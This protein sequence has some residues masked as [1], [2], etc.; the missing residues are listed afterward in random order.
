M[1]SI[2]DTIITEYNIY[3]AIATLVTMV[4]IKYI[5]TFFFENKFK[6]K[7][8]L[9]KAILISRS[10][11]LWIF[12]VFV[13]KDIIFVNH[14]L[15]GIAFYISKGLNV[16]FVYIVSFSTYEILSYFI[17]MESS[18]RR[19][20]S[21]RVAWKLLLK[22]TIFISAIIITLN[23]TG[24][25]ELMGL[26]TTIASI[27]VFL[28]LTSSTWFP[29][30]KS[31]LLMLF[32]NSLS[33]EDVIEVPELDIYGVVNSIGLFSTVIRNEIDNHRILV[34]NDKLEKS[35]INNIS[36]LSRVGGLREQLIFNIG[37]IKDNGEKIRSEEIKEY[38]EEAFKN[39]KL[40]KLDININFEK[41]IEIFL[42]NPGDHALTWHV[43]YFTDNIKTRIKDK[44]Y[45]YEIFYNCSIKYNIGLDTPITS[46][47]LEN[48]IKGN[49]HE[50]S[51]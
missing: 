42:H 30:I 31:G 45:M 35:V 12:M 38:F 27:G 49:F 9:K 23:I 46:V 34:A 32:S 40:S 20:S 51:I 4:L 47:I 11:I 19:R 29:P 50:K 48:N 39:A 24:L 41:P 33:E 1:Q 8:S 13:V 15:N 16:L 5:L 2:L 21:A 17:D 36:K 3:F 22:I 18:K 28:G 14:D 10:V 44:A 37:Y 43:F 6:K 7:E 26:G 25:A